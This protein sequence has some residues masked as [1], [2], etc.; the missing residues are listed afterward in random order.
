MSRRNVLK[1]SRGHKKRTSNKR[2]IK[3]SHLKVLK[4]ERRIFINKDHALEYYLQQD[5]M[6]YEPSL[7]AK[8][9]DLYESITFAKERTSFKGKKKYKKKL[10]SHHESHSNQKMKKK[11][12]NYYDFEKSPTR[13]INLKKP[14]GKYSYFTENLF[15]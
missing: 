1:A 14:K 4:K 6:L 5:N 15:K 7:D 11:T 13:K 12:Q 3:G 9:H 10:R 8:I 2:P